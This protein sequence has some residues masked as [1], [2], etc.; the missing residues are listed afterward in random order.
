MANKGTCK[1][2]NCDKEV[3]AK[4]YCRRMNVPFAFSSNG[5]MFVEFD[6]VTGRGQTP[7]GRKR[8]ERFGSEIERH[9]IEPTRPTIWEISPQAAHPPACGSEFASRHEYLGVREM[10]ETA[11]VIDVKSFWHSHSFDGTIVSSVSLFQPM[12]KSATST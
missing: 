6:H 8:S 12:A 5:R 9:G 11:V 4:G 7:A 2:E 1:A 3:Q 10:R